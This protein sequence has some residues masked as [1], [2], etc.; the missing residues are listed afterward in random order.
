MF[1]SDDRSF[2]P[3]RRSR[4]KIFPRNDSAE[5]AGIHRCVVDSQRSSGT[6]ACFYTTHTEGHY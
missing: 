6:C 1:V 2:R 5:A 3:N 4:I